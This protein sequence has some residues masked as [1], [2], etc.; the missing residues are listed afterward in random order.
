A[1]SETE[2]IQ[3]ILNTSLNDVPEFAFEDECPPAQAVL[4][5][6][7]DLKFGKEGLEQLA[8]CETAKTLDRLITHQVLSDR[9]VGQPLKA[10]IAR[11]GA[12]GRPAARKEEFQ[13]LYAQMLLRARVL[14]LAVARGQNVDGCDIRAIVEPFLEPFTRDHDLVLC[15]PFQEIDKS[16]QDFIFRHSLHVAL[17]ALAIAAA[18]GYNEEQVV[19]IAMSGLLHDC[20][21]LLVPRAIRLK[22]GKLTEDEWFEVQ[23]HPILGI[24][25][26]EKIKHLPENIAFVA[27][28]A[29]EREN[30][31]GYPK[32]R[33]GRFIH[34]YA[35][36]V[37]VADM[38][39]ALSSPRPY[40]SSYI[41]YRAM[42]MLIK[43]T[44]QNLVDGEVIKGLLEYYSLYVVGSL[45]QLSNGCI[46][47]IV[48]ANG[49]HFAKPVVS[50]LTNQNLELL[51]EMLIYQEDLVKNEDV[52]IVKV[53]DPHHLPQVSLLAGF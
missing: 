42:E 19:Q 36:I 12:V 44:R 41:P 23:K 38:F 6:V 9:P 47:R 11:D 50:V 28:Q 10:K 30:G 16:D 5:Q 46:G 27:Y 52:Q 3:Q 1:G 7:K 35:K 18:R 24:N 8:G 32:Q 21:M 15:L 48:H 22:N 34:G 17:I 26:L 14:L 33:M 4:A 51:N 29:H 25:L 13:R 37:Q 43:M 2:E 39:E 20:G 40:R 45:A 49:Q 31:K 53:F